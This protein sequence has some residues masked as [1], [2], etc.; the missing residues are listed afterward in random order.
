M[1]ILKYIFLSLLFGGLISFNSCSLDEVIKDTPTPAT[2]TSET[3]VTAIIGG[4]YSRFNDASMFKFQSFNM[5]ILGADDIFSTAG[6]EAGPYAQRTFSSAN[7]A[8]MWN[9]LY[10]CIANANNLIE[11]LDK[12][13]LSPAFEKRAYGEAYFIRAFSYY[14]LVRLYGGA[15]I[16]NTAIHFDTD[17][18]LPKNTV[19]ELY[20][21]IL[22]DFKLASENLPLQS[23]IGADELGRASK[24]AAQAFLSEAY[25]TYGNQLSLAGQSPITQ[26][27]QSVLYADSVIDSKKY[28]LLANFGDLFDINKETGAYSEVIFGVR[29]QTDAS[30]R[31]QPA[32][33][34]EYASNFGASNTFGVS[35]SGGNGNNTFRVSHWFADYYRKGDYSNGVSKFTPNID[36]RNEKA[37]VQRGFNANNGRFFAVYP[38]IPGSTVP[39]SSTDGTINDPLLAKY[40]DPGGK[41]ARNHG[42]DLFIIRFSAIYLIKAEALNELNG[43]T[44]P[45]LDAFNMV[46]ARARTVNSV[47]EART[48]PA[49]LTLTTAVD[50]KTFRL[51]IFDERGLEFIGEAVRWFDLVRM[52]SPLN[53]SQTMYEYQFKTVL[54]DATKYPRILPTGYNASTQLYTPNTSRENAIYAPIL[55]VS[56]PKF[57]LFPVPNTELVLNTKFGQQNPGW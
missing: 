4:M 22:S 24:G 45:A 40:Q 19:D 16:R 39:G 6:S 38:N 9:N 10:A 43:P 34:S 14:Y 57:L 7:T 37:F 28:V 25:L 46:R 11:V 35:A 20:T 54:S 47:P 32:A 2:A 44:Q 15:P 50:K 53:S 51:K 13:T 5:L 49:N 52:Q 8:P 18:Y 48:I 36:Y 23:S 56:V 12:L 26:Y 3:D 17:F 31:A 1:K 42:N 29:F 30:A 55:N 21:Q 27:Q 33:G 41:D